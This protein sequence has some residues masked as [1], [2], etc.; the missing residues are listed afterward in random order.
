MS[1]KRRI[2][3]TERMAEDLGMA[4]ECFLAFRKKPGFPSP[5]RGVKHHL[6]W[7]SIAIH[8]YFDKLG[9]IQPD[10]A[11][12]DDVIFRRLNG[13]GAREISSHP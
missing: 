6:W 4:A 2:L 3:N 12:D 11:S 8:N 7:D 5:V 9:N 10:S 13:K 1:E